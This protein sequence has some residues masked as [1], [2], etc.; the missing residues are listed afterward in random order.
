MKRESKISESLISNDDDAGWLVT[1]A[2]LVTLLLVFFVLLYSIS[3]IEQVKFLSALKTIKSQ[4]EANSFFS[5]YIDMFDFPDYGNQL[6]S[7]EERTGLM[8]RQDSLIRDVNKFIT[9]NNDS[10]K[11]TTFVRMGKI[12][13][14]L[15]GNYVFEPGSAQINKGFIPLLQSLLDIMYEYPDYVLNIKGH[16]D[17]AH[18]STDQY[19]SNWELSSAR[20]MEVL[21]YLVRNGVPPERLTATGY[22]STMPLVSNSSAENREKNR[23]VEFV[24]EKETYQY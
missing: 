19:P 21:K 24:L 4:I 20:A 8:S 18:I 1:Y 12:I 13:I 10:N 23:R 9:Q 5:Q 16:T 3:S 17:D 15:D 11:L 7:I 6:I 2:D 14:R 22:G